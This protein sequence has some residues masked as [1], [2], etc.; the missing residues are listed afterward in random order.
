VTSPAGETYAFSCP[1]CCYQY[2]D[3]EQLSL[4]YITFHPYVKTLT[5]GSVRIDTHDEN[6]VSYMC[7]ETGVGSGS[8]Y[9]ENSLYPTHDEAMAAA[10]EQ[11]ESSFKNTEWVAKL[12]NRTLEVSQHSMLKAVEFT[13]EKKLNELGWAVRWLIEGLEDCETM[14]QVKREIEKYTEKR[15][16]A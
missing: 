9:N 13:S 14:E 2:S 1:R 8:I 15:D 6:P 5:I 10:K 7:R 16:A 3:R 4:S 11:A 12:Y